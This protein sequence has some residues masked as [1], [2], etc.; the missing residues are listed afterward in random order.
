MSTILKTAAASSVLASFRTIR[1]YTTVPQPL[2]TQL[3]TNPLSKASASPT[4]FIS[5]TPLAPSCNQ[6]NRCLTHCWMDD[7]QREQGQRCLVGCWQTNHH[8]CQAQDCP[9]S[10]HAACASKTR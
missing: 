10:A 8:A 7:S 2:Q 5:R 4:L 1:A 3:W 9:N 6:N